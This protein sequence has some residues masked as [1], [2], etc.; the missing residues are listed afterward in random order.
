[1]SAPQGWSAEMDAKIE[2]MLRDPEGYWA[3]AHAEARQ[4]VKAA[5]RQRM[6]RMV[7]RWLH[8]WFA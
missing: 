2:W 8:R 3:H 7:P 6:L 1:M 5:E 4:I